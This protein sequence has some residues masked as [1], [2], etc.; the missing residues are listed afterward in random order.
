MLEY[1]EINSA[2][3]SLFQRG[4][5]TDIYNGAKGRDFKHEKTK[6]K[7]QSGATVGGGGIDVGAVNSTSFDEE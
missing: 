6:M 7:R 3:V 4:P 2:I 1:C 5:V